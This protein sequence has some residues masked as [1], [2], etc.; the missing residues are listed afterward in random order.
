MAESA[1][2]VVNARLQEGKSWLQKA[3]ERVDK[4]IDAIPGRA[5]GAAGAVGGGVKTGVEATAAVVALPFVGAVELVKK[6][7]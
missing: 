2:N 1:G 5:K 7:S 3:G 6:N 4:I